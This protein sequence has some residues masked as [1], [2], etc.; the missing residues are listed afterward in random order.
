MF[1]VF[2]LPLVFAFIFSQKQFD[3]VAKY[4]PAGDIQCRQKGHRHTTKLQGLKHLI[5]A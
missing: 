1:F 4:V 3:S 5:T 2:R